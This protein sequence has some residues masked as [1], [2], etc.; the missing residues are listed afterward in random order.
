M[1]KIEFI[2]YDTTGKMTTHSY[3]SPLPPPID[4][5]TMAR[6]DVIELMAKYNMVFH[7]EGK[8]M[9]GNMGT[10]LIYGIDN[11]N[12]HYDIAVH[13]GQFHIIKQHTQR[14]S[15]FVYADI[16]TIDSLT[17]DSLAL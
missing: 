4:P 2:F 7:A 17:I 15:G 10:N 3:V 6:P 5:T 12:C 14:T 1:K 8:W 11:S 9:D 16:K 13:S